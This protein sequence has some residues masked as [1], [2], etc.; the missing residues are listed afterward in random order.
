MIAALVEAVERLE[1][2]PKSGRSVPE[3]EELAIREVLK[4]AYRIIYQINTDSI[5]IVAVVHVSM[6]LPLEPPDGD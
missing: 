1:L 2:F 6:M 5:D 3:Y 4:G